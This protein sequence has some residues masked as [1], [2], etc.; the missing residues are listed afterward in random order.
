[1][2]WLDRIIGWFSPEAGYRRGAFR[3]ALRGYDAASYD[4]PNVNWRVLNE[5]AE[6][7][8][9][10]SR[11]IIRARAR[12][13]ERNSDILNSVTGAYKRNVFGAGYR[14]RAA[15]GDEGLDQK[16]EK[17]WKIWCKKQNCDVTGLQSFAS[18]MR[19]AVQRKKIDGGI[20]FLK[21]YT[22]GGVLPFKLQAL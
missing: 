22:S 6:M 4:R 5:P 15:S 3:E 19:M 14:L 16:L 7:T 12:D 21:R 2:N 20:L 1:M 10:M 9:R 13:L 18:M 8:D 11:D 17:L